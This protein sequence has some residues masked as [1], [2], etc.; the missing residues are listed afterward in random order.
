MKFNF[1]MPVKVIAGA[2]SDN[3]EVLKSFGKKPL[4]VCGKS[5]AKACGAIG[6]IE[7]VFGET[8]IYNKIEPNPSVATVKNGAQFAK[9]IGADFI[10]GIGG[11]SPLDAAKMIAVWA[12]CDVPIDGVSGGQR[13]P[14]VLI[15]TTIGTGSEV[16]KYS[17]LT[18]PETHSKV[19]IAADLLF[20]DLALLDGKYCLGLPISVSH[21]TALDALCHCIEGILSKSASPLSDLFAKEGIRIISSKF[22]ALMDGKISAADYEQLLY[23]STLAGFVIA[24]TGTCAVHAAGYALTSEKNIDHGRANALL[25]TDILRRFPERETAKLYEIMGLSEVEFS[26][27]LSELLG[28]H[29]QITADEVKVFAEKTMLAKN[30]SNGIFAPDIEEVREIYRNSLEVI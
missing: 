23:A 10:I 3:A 1:F 13:L 29:D 12:K 27:Y 6:D 9:E 16:T 19:N 26:L 14:L 21:N 7:A 30:I 8:A 25:L 11:G 17:V 18:V 4:I 24:Q 15:P 28:K 22:G 20:P 2:V 5:S